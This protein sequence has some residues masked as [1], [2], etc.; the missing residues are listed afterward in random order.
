MKEK[1]FLEKIHLNEGEWNYLNL[2]EKIE[3]PF[4][5]GFD[6]KG[7]VIIDVESMKEEFEKKMEILS[8]II[9]EAKE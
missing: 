7:D 2:N 5:Y 9:Q 4:Y 3:I 8:E 6:E 1:E